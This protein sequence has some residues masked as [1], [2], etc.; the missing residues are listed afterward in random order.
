MEIKAHLDASRESLFLL[1]YIMVVPCDVY[2]IAQ[3][4][5]HGVAESQNAGQG[6]KGLVTIPL[7]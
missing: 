6:Q 7:N 4:L 2:C 1:S 3:L 5:W